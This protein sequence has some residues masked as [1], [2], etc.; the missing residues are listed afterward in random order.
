M[1]VSIRAPSFVFIDCRVCTNCPLREVLWILWAP[2]VLWAFVIGL[3]TILLAT[4]ITLIYGKLK[5]R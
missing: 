5:F 2:W 1:E 3:G 4:V